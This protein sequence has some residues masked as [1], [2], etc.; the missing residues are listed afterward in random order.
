MPIFRAPKLPSPQ[1]PKPQAWKHQHQ[2]LR[3]VVAQRG[4][5][6]LTLSHILLGLHVVTRSNLHSQQHSQNLQ[7]DTHSPSETQTVRLAFQSLTK[8][9]IL[10]THNRLKAQTTRLAIQPALDQDRPTKSFKIGYSQPLESS[11]NQFDRPVS[12]R[13]ENSSRQPAIE[14]PQSSGN[15]DDSP[16]HSGP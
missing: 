3:G 9:D 13:A 8:Q 5:L 6:R 15:T 1:A 11:D 2:V 14:H 7:L 12:T 10:D 16:A 4:L